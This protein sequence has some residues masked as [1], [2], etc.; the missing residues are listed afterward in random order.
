MFILMAFLLPFLCVENYISTPKH[1]IE[2][3]LIPIVI[4]LNAIYR[5]LSA[6]PDFLKS[7]GRGWADIVLLFFLLGPFS[8]EFQSG[9]EPFFYFFDRIVVVFLLLML[10]S[11]AILPKFENI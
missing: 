10:T 1:A 2:F 11:L 3:I 8:F 5:F 4:L 6:K 7:I 9:F